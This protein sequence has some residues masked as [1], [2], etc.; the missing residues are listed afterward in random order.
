MDG[1]TLRQR[2][3]FDLLIEG[4]TNKQIGLQLGISHRTVEDHQD[5]I[6]KKL[7]VHNRVQL[8]RKALAAAS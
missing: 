7:G 8:V 4:L 5:V 3:V 6:F 2:Q 1:L